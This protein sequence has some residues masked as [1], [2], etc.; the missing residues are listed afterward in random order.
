MRLCCAHSYYHNFSHM[1]IDPN[2]NYLQIKNPWKK[3][4]KNS[5]R[6]IYIYRCI[7]RILCVGH[8]TVSWLDI[9]PPVLFCTHHYTSH[10]NKSGLGSARKL[11]ESLI[12]T[13]KTEYETFKTSRQNSAPL[14][15]GSTSGYAPP[16][17]GM[18]RV[19]VCLSVC[20]YVFFTEFKIKKLCTSSALGTAYVWWS[21]QGIIML[22]YE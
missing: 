9:Y 21:A 19:C 16:P 20:M 3:N 11:S 12:E 7:L 22:Y 1:L 10:P 2:I 14:G 17:P 5:S 15:F 4:N 18:L 8:M 6:D 13:V